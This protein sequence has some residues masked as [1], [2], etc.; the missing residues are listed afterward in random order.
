MYI[1]FFILHLSVLLTPASAR[2][3][4]WPNLGHGSKR[5]WNTAPGLQ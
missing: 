1:Y 2:K 5:I 4:Q 3:I